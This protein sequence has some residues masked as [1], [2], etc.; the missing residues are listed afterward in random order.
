MDVKSFCQSY[1]AIAQA[2]QAASR[3]PAQA[4]QERKRLKREA[5][6]YVNYVEKFEIFF[7]LYPALRKELFENLPNLKIG[8]FIEYQLD[9]FYSDLMKIETLKADV[10]KE[11]DT[12]RNNSSEDISRRLNEEEEKIS[13][14]FRHLSTGNVQSIIG[15]LDDRLAYLKRLTDASKAGERQAEEERR[16]LSSE[17]AKKRVSEMTELEIQERRKRAQDEYS[18]QQRRRKK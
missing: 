11:I 15:F 4:E 18:R 17:E 2:M 9:L 7:D 1:I 10:R 12:L 5:E 13:G 8:A 6:E 16:R 3:K 14:C